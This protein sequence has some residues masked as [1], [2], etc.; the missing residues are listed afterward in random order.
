MVIP[1]KD[2]IQWECVDAQLKNVVGGSSLTLKDGVA[3]G[4]P[5]GPAIAKIFLGFHESR[6]FDNTVQ[7]GFDLWMIL[8]HLSL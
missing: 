6:L 7:P 5:L 2:D 4:S 1:L 8:C 3:M